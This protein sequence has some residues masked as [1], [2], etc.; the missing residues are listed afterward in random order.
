[1]ILAGD[2]GG[3]KTELAIFDS[4]D[5]QMRGPKF[6]RRYLNREQDNLP[7]M[8]QNFLRDAGLSIT[9][10][11]FA[12][13]G[14]VRAGRCVMPNLPWVVDGLELQQALGL[15]RVALINDLEATAYGIPTLSPEEFAVINQGVEDVNGN[16][17]LIAAGTGLG[18]AIMFRVKD[19]FHISA[20]EGGHTDFAAQNDEEAGLFR[21]LYN[22]YDCHVSYERVVS[23]PGLAD[24][25]DYFLSCNDIAES[26]NL[27]EYIKEAPDRSAAITELSLAGKSKI[28]A[29]TLDL[30]IRVYGAEASNLALKTLATGGIYIGGGIAPK[31]LPKLQ[32]GRFFQAFCAKGRFS[33]LVADIPVK[34][35][36]NEKT[37]MRGAAAFVFKAKETNNK[38]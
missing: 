7:A 18:E 2:I 35:I 19:G 30:F 24:I 17:A 12:V 37:A 34:V 25:Y 29:A 31:I 6:E 33:G 10:A 4:H 27:R 13:A 26:E 3:T 20:T 16:A 8:V 28:C 38:K 21:F 22:K 36:L 11:C 23:G 32:D 1:M 15:T 9:D 5:S 14:P